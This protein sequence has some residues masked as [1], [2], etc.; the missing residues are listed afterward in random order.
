MVSAE[1]LANTSAVSAGPEAK[2][3]M[4]FASKVDWFSNEFRV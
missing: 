4:S 2:M 3:L 1:P